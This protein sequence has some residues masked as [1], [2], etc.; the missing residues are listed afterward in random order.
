MARFLGVLINED[1]YC[2]YYFPIILSADFSRIGWPLEFHCRMII[3]KLLAESKR[4]LNFNGPDK[5]H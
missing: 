4:G 5:I 1:T 3:G 2:K